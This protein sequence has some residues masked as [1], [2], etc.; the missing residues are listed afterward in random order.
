M[1][2]DEINELTAAAVSGLLLS[3]PFPQK[4]VSDQ[5][6]GNRSVHQRALPLALPISHFFLSFS[7]LLNQKSLR[8]GFQR[9]P[10][11]ALLS[12]SPTA[13]APAFGAAKI[14]NVDAGTFFGSH[15][16]AQ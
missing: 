12:G 15:E 8:I 7:E 16:F 5:H 10:I 11:T 4:T 14:A 9:F 2:A 3:S 6:P 13:E 1:E